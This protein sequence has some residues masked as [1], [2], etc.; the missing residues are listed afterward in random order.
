[1]SGLLDGIGAALSK[2]ANWLPNRQ[3]HYRNK[4]EDITNEMDILQAQGLNGNRSDKYERLAQQLRNLRKKT[5][6]D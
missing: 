5:K 1:M 6:N 3:E 4:I 2:I